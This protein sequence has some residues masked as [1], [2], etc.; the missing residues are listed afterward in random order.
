MKR[1]NR[2]Y[3]KLNYY[4]VQL[5]YDKMCDTEKRTLGGKIF[6]HIKE[7]N[8]WAHIL[9]KMLEKE[10]NKHKVNKRR[11]MTEIKKKKR[12]LRIQRQFGLWK[13]SLELTKQ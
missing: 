10:T 6:Y 8:Q 2:K 5:N 11:D 13:N 3:Y 9:L 4:K 12:Q 7:L 1:E